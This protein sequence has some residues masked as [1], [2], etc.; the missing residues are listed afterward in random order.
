MFAWFAEN[1]VTVAALAG[2]LVLIGIAVF[3]LV[4]EKKN[5]S[6]GCTGNCAACGMA[7]SYGRSEK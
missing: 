3:T 1:A 6:G 5:K 2:V 7:C 4:R